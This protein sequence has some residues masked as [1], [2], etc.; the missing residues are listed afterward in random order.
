MKLTSSLTMGQAALPEVDGFTILTIHL[1]SQADC[2]DSIK[3]FP[4]V[5]ST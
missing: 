1:D 2:D 3:F 5:K 4:A